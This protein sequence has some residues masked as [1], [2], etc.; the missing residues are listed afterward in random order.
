MTQAPA[1]RCIRPADRFRCARGRQHDP[2]S[3][4]LSIVNATAESAASSCTV[5]RRHETAHAQEN[6][7]LV[8]ALELLSVA[9]GARRR[10]ARASRDRPPSERSSRSPGQP[11]PCVPPDAPAPSSGPRPGGQD[12]RHV[13]PLVS[14]RRPERRPLR[15]PS[16]LRV[17]SPAAPA[18][19]AGMPVVVMLH[20]CKQSAESFAAGTRIC[21]LAERSGFAVLFP[22]QAKTAHAHRCWHWHGDATESE[23]APS[24]RWS[25]PSCDSTASTATGSTWP[26]C[27]PEPGRRRTGHPVSRPLR[28]RRPAL[29]P[30]HRPAVVDVGGD[31][32][33]APGPARRPDTRGR[34]VRRR[35]VLSR[36]AGPRHARRTR[37]GRDRPERDAARHRVRAAQPA[38]RRARRDAGGRATHLC[39]RRCRLR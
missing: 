17:V 10:S 36:H 26:A 2:C 11:P 38:R 32:P 9:A 1:F 12:A 39:A 16:C 5:G 15:E 30:G 18:T 20:G 35:R 7:P 34:C 6:Q 4:P 24:R 37:Y 28:G 19:T 21:R 13:A 25:T 29:R 22:E 8:A 23:A 31:E 27:P 14:F 3:A 33:D